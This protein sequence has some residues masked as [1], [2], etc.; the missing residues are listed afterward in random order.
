[1]KKALSVLIAVLVMG[2]IVLPVSAMQ[3]G[4]FEYGGYTITVVPY[5]PAHP[6]H[7]GSFTITGESEAAIVNLAGEYLTTTRPQPVL[8]VSVAGTIETPDAILNVEKEW[9]MVPRETHN[10]WRTVVAW[11]DSLIAS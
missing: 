10:V 5:D 4:T 2:A 8:S 7:G 6:G 11:I 1:M 9:V 3:K